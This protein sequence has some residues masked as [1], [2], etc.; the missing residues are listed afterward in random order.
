MLDKRY[1]RRPACRINSQVRQSISV[2][3]ALFTMNKFLLLLLLVTS[4]S[5]SAQTP[6]NDFLDIPALIKECFQNGSGYYFLNEYTHVHKVIQ[7]KTEK[8]G[9]VKE[10]SE[11]YEAYAPTFK[12]KGSRLVKIKT[13]ENGVPLSEEKLEK[14]R[15]EASG[16]LIK[17]EAAA[18]KVA[19]EI[20]KAKAES[21]AIGVYFGLTRGS[22]F[23]P[24]LYFNVKIV[25]QHG[26]FENPHRENLNGREMIVLDWKI[27]PDAKLENPEKYLARLKGRVWIDV[28]EHIVAKLD[29]F[30]LNSDQTRPVIY[31]DG[32]RLPD[33][34]WM[35]NKYLVNCDGNAALFDNKKMTDLMV[36][37]SDYKHFDSEV[38]DEKIFAPTAKD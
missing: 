31:Y 20:A 11:T 21:K 3:P 8:N 13:Q 32:I 23:G 37:F 16:K 2:L 35:P 27:K 30:A 12:G 9:Q 6:A 14:A 24:V 17:E 29:G 25:L 18:A 28:A 33:G 34:K 5:I 38:K 19:E 36:E 26:A 7:R 4:F 22:L 1:D 10:T 15:K